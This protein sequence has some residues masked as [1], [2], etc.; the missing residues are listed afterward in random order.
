MRRLVTS[1]VVYTRK[2]VP[3]V[4]RHT[5]SSRQSPSRSAV[6]VGVFLVPLFPEHWAQ[7]SKVPPPA[8]LIELAF[9][10]S[11]HSSASQYMTKLLPE[12]G[13]PEA[14]VAHNTW[15]GPEHD[16]LVSSPVPTYS[17]RPRLASVPGLV[18]RK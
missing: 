9:S 3:A 18:M 12:P 4:S 15:P 7:V 17:A 13:P 11:R 1:V 2:A 10:S 16:A 5:T 8:L 6:M 14:P